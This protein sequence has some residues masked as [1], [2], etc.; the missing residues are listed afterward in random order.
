MP[1]NDIQRIL[2]APD[3]DSMSALNGHLAA[4]M[5]KRAQLDELINNVESTIKTIKGEITMT[6]EEKFKGFKEK[7]V[8]DNERQFGKEIRQKFGDETVEKS[9]ARVL[10]MTREQYDETKQLTEEL[11]AALKAAVEQ[12]DPAGPLARKACELHKQWLSK[13]WGSYS[14]EAHIGITEMYVA[15]ERFKAYYEKIAPGCAEFL[16]EAVKVYCK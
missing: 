12:G 2:S 15:D 8:A 4:L 10:N 13:F 7:L 11:N 14:K 6:D 5:A 1:I 3:F 16:R 9:N